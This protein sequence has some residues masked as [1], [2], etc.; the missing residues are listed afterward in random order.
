MSASDHLGRQWHQ[1]ELSFEGHRGL[2]DVLPHE[3]NRHK[4]GMHWSKDPVMATYF[5]ENNVNGEYTGQPGLIYHAQIPLS[6]V[7]TDPHTL[8]E[9]SVMPDNH[10]EKEIPVKR[11]AKVT[12]VARTKVTPTL[13]TD[14]SEAPPRMRRRNYN[15]PREMKA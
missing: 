2:N 15:P 8:D 3:V 6:S 4:L 13:D 12:V 10:E 1:P 5:S 11:G 14:Y 7:E 9:H